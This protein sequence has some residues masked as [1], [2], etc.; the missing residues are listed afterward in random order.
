MYCLK[1]ITDDLI[2]VGGND[3]RLAM[4]EGVYSVPDGVSYNSYLM[5][6][7]KT[8]LFDTVDKAVSKV[9][10]ENLTEVLGERPLDYLVVHHMEPDH[11]F[12]LEEVVLRYPNLKI[13]CNSKI[14]TIIK[15]FFDFDI[16]SRAI[17]V[18][19]GEEL[20]TGKHQLKFYMAPMVHWPEV[21]MTYDTTDGI[22]FSA[23]AFG[24]FGALNGAIFAD[25]VDFQQN[26]MEEARRYYSNIIGKYGSQVQAVLKKIVPLE[27]RL[28]CPLHG[29]VWR[30]D[31]EIYLEKYDRWSSYTPEEEGV[32]IA[33]ASIYGN[34]E[35]AA[36]ILASRLWDRGI[37][38]I[39]FDVS[40]THASDIITAAFRYSHLVFASTT[41][42]N[43]IFVS[44]EALIF[45]IVAHNL[46]N[47]TIAVIENGSWAPNS[48]K[49]IRTELE[50]CKNMNIL[51]NKL[52]IKST[53]KKNQ[54]SE[55]D[56]M[57]DTIAE[58]LLQKA[59][60]SS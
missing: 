49:L 47:R 41:Y 38:A 32:V 42:N 8:V 57:V 53:L 56:A 2:W 58:T 39:M 21:M 1:K 5:M 14:V 25:E 4:F 27:I 44:M 29:F 6:D 54:L 45:D 31:I 16:D 9:F 40:V 3:R 28:L 60:K 22:L 33:Y 7:E 36:E 59:R 12:T 46:Q 50:K 18:K 10:F 48:G 17:I 13:I 30:K 11:S 15:Q 19:E 43:G 35:N 37:K 23:D 51:E 24:C 26:Y 55:I 52:S 34:T 20:S